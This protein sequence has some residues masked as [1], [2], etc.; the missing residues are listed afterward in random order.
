MFHVRT[1]LFNLDLLKKISR[2]L[3]GVRSR[4]GSKFQSDELHVG[5]C[6]GN[7]CVISTEYY[8]IVGTKALNKNCAHIRHSCRT[9]KMSRKRNKFLFNIS[10][11]SNFVYCLVFKNM[12]K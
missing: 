4:Y 7:N 11:L 2:L 12:A 8:P 5:L 3:N 10:S 9:H 6:T 1:F